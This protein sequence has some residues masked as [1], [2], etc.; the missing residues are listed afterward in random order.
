MSVYSLQLNT[1]AI[2]LNIIEDNAK[3]VLGHVL[4]NNY[5]IDKTVIALPDYVMSNLKPK[6]KV[7]LAKLIEDNLV[8]AKKDG[9]PITAFD[10]T[11]IG[12]V[13]TKEVP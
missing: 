4:G 3:I 5:I 12:Y 7:H 9:T 11:H 1:N 6:D 2:A 8:T 13:D 10:A